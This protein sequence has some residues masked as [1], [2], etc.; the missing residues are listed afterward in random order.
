[1]VV[2]GRRTMGD[3]VA[4]DGMGGRFGEKERVGGGNK[5]ALMPLHRAPTVGTCLTRDNASCTKT[6]TACFYMG[7]KLP[8]AARKLSEEPE[9]QPP[10]LWDRQMRDRYRDFHCNVWRGNGGFWPIFKI[11]KIRRKSRTA[12]QKMLHYHLRLVIQFLNKWVYIVKG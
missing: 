3:R 1:M 12:V 11:F 2:D 6:A 5:A 7:S 8:K 9:L 10:A 4:N